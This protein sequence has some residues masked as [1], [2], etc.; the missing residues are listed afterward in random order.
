MIYTVDDLPDL[1][2]LYSTILEA[3]D[4]CVKAFNNRADALDAL[5]A[6]RTK[7]D[8]LI[9][10]FLGH[11]MPVERFLQRCLEIHPTLRI[12]MASGSCPTAGQFPQATP[13]RFIQ[14]PF[15]PDE[16]RQ[17]VRAALKS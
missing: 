16:L 3:T 4:Y 12:L 5:E 14:K 2:E 9:T 15:T 10:D 1:T 8:L 11:A 7:P 17:E 13:D 6:D